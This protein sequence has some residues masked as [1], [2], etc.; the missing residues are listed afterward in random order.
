MEGKPVV[1]MNFGGIIVSL[2]LM[3]S[4]ALVIFY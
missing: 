2:L 3:I 1:D 4:G